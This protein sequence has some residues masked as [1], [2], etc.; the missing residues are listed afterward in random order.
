LPVN[1]I[2]DETVCLDER[3]ESFLGPA[4]SVRGIWM[5]HPH[6][7]GGQEQAT[8]RTQ[9]PSGFIEDKGRV[10]DVL[11]LLRRQRDVDRR[12]PDG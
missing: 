7:M 3:D 11:E 6:A 2:D 5:V 10:E 4:P 8:T 12:R 9:R 1:A